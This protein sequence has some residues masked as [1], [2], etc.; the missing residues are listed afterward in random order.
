[1]GWSRGGWRGDITKRFKSL[2]QHAHLHYP[3]TLN[4][5]RPF[6]SNEILKRTVAMS[7]TDIPTGSSVELYVYTCLL[8]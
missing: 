8:R 1:M 5:V 3:H 6:N 4:D 2:L 7:C